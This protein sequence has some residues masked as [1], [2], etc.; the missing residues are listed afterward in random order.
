MRT[1]NL[2]LMLG[3][4]IKNFRPENLDTDP[5]VGDLVAAQTGRLWFNTT[6]GKY[7]YFDGT[8]IKALGEGGA[9]LDGVIL[10][11]GTVA[12]TAD[13]EL[14]GDDQS[15]SADNAAVSKKHVETVVGT[16]QDKITGLTQNGVVIA[17]ADNALQ[18]STVTAAELGYLSGVTSGI[19]T[20]LTTISGDVSDLTTDV[21]GK[22]DAAN[23][24]LTGDLNADGNTVTN[25][26]APSSPNDAARK[27][28][29]DNAIAG[30]DWLADI[31]AIQTDGTLDPELVA[32]KRYLILDAETIN[33]NFGTI[34]GL[35][36]N[37]IVQYV[38]SAFVI[39]FDPTSP[40]AGGAVTWSKADT[41]YRRFD[42]TAWGSFGGASDFNP[43]NGLEKVAN[44]VNVKTGDGIVITDNAV[45][46]G[47]DTNSGLEFN[48]NKARV[49]LNGSSLS[50][51]VDGIG[52]A[53]DGVTYAKI[54]AAALGAGL[55]KDAGTSKIIVDTAALKTAGFIDAE[56]GEVG[57][58]TLTGEDPLVDASVVSKKYVDDA[59]AAG[60]A[61]G[62]AKLYQYDK[63]A[64]GDAAATAHTFTHNAGVKYGTVTV[65]DDTGYQII[66][67]EVVF[68]DANSLRVELSTAKKV[69][70]AFVTGVNAYVE[71]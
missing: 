61:S 38:G 59:V 28:D 53:D 19:Q 70:I 67:D 32:G 22:L 29:I 8:V 18:T 55:T 49:K 37:M 10:A 44:V 14:S 33:P 65:V 41:D 43:G 45:T 50:R 71:V 6:E 11:D 42:G 21:A 20:Q 5:V 39:K 25:L 40:E 13:L 52:I 57:A 66:P 2:D 48:A 63:T 23:G 15:A 9:S 35:T 12:M 68:V 60:S 30:I 58:L 27:I 51:T 1:G 16:K 62:A 69:A 26:A 3:A 47:L 7:K 36:D 4:A 24:T 64:G 54:A 31:D 17:G 56:G 34:T 46:L